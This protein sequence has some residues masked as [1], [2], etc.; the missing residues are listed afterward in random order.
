MPEKIIC[1]DCGEEFEL[2]EHAPN[3]TKRCKSCGEKATR[4]MRIDSAHRSYLKN[5]K[6]SKMAKPAGYAI[7]GPKEVCDA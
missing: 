2:S 1:Q 4:Q 7:S 6:P 5:G 3:T